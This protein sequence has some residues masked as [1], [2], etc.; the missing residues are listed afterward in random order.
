[1]PRRK[2]KFNKNTLAVL[3]SRFEGGKKEMSI[4]QIK[5]QLRITSQLVKM[6]SRWLVVLLK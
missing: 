2:R 3:I 1:M 6:D 4:A 5:E